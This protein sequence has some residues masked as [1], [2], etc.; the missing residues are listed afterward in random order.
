MGNGMP[1]GYAKSCENCAHWH[2][3]EK[4]GRPWGWE[5]GH[6]DVLKRMVV[7]RRYLCESWKPRTHERSHRRA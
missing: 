5:G 1:E 6:C 3:A 2:R 4:R 7:H